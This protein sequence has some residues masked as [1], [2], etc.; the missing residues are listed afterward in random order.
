MD[1]CTITRYTRLQS[2]SRTFV[3]AHVLQPFSIHV[4]DFFSH[5]TDVCKRTCYS[6]FQY[7]LWMFRYNLFDFMRAEP[8]HG[9]VVG[10]CKRACVCMRV[11][12][13]SVSVCVIASMCVTTYTLLFSLTVG[14]RAHP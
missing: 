3:N 10:A 8:M 14:V 7:M 6:R 13:V 4:M 2:M 12:W 9:R 11:W 1:G 5:I